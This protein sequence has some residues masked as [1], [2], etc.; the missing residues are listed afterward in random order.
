MITNKRYRE[1]ER[2]VPTPPD[3]LFTVCPRCGNRHAVKMGENAYCYSDVCD[4][5]EYPLDKCERARRALD[6]LEADEAAGVDVDKFLSAVEIA[7]E[8][9]RWPPEEDTRGLL[10]GL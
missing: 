8:I 1:Y 2:R 10:I 7:D 4:G 6:I 3:H 5:A 9:D